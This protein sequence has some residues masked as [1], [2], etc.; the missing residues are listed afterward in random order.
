MP[1][2]NST[3]K[4]TMLSMSLDPLKPD[5]VNITLSSYLKHSGSWATGSFGSGSNGSLISLFDSNL[6]STTSSIHITIPSS[7]YLYPNSKNSSSISQLFNKYTGSKIDYLLQIV[8]T[9][10][11]TQPFICY[12]GSTCYPGEGLTSNPPFTPYQEFPSPYPGASSNRAYTRAIQGGISIT[13]TYYSQP[14]NP[15]GNTYLGTLGLVCQDIATG[16]LVGL[17]NN[18]VIVRDAFY[19][20]QRTY[21]SPQ[22]EFDL[23]DGD[24][25]NTSPFSYQSLVYQQQEPVSLVTGT[26]SIGRVIRYVPLYTKTTTLSNPTK[27]NKVDAAIMSLY[28]TSSIGDPIINT[29]SSFKQVGLDTLFPTNVGLPFATTA[30]IDGMIDPTSIY[31]NPPLASS[32][33]TTGPKSG[34][35][36]PLR[37]WGICNIDIAYKKQSIDTLTIMQDVI[38]FVKPSDDT[39]YDLSNSSSAALCGFPC[40][41]GDSGS[42]LYAKLNGS[43]KVI[44]LVFAGD[45]VPLQNIASTI[46]YACRIDNVSQS[47]GVKAWLGGQAPVVDH[48][49]IKLV[50]ISGSN[51]IKTQTCSGS[52][53]YQ[54]GLTTHHKPC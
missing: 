52:V 13:S 6:F 15:Q 47:L 3:I 16:A 9:S 17:T 8:E 29:T 34:S 32:G 31:Y 27:I 20:N 11:E 1:I 43:W 4:N 22:N 2:Y 26:N 28:C 45:G 49:T 54:V 18:H 51:D 23:A 42:S 30:E 10:G 14:F 33:R 53:Y 7:S 21:I 5:G 19:T 25:S 24:G 36:C 44:G 12:S 41:A 39:T 50:S 35:S 48:D 37:I 46:G 38:A 40:W